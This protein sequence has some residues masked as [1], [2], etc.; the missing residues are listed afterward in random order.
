MLYLLFSEINTWPDDEEDEAHGHIRAAMQF[1]STDQ[2]FVCH[3]MFEVCCRVSM[4]CVLA[5]LTV[6]N[7]S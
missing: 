1:H 5:Y 4:A 2:E 6:Y 3:T 7:T